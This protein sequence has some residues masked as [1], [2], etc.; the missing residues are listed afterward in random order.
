MSS[1]ARRAAIQDV[2]RRI[3]LTNTEP[4]VALTEIFA[5]NVF[6]ERVQRQR[7]PKRVYGLLRETTRSGR[8]L[9]PTI[10]DAVASAMRDWAVE[11]GATHYS[12]WFQPMTGLT[13]EK[14]DSFISLTEDER[15]INEFSG[16]DLIR[17]EPD[18]SSF[19]SGGLRSTFEARGYTAWDPTSPAFIRE[20][21][22][23]KTLC[24]PTV[25]CS[26]TGEALDK[27]TPLLRSEEAIN[28]ASVRL[29][30]LIGNDR[31]TQVSTTI[32]CEQEYFLVDRQ[33]AHLRPDLLA[34]G[35][36]LFGARPPKGQEMSD[37]YFGAISQRALAFMQDLEIDLWR[38]GIPVK[39]RHNEVA[40]MQFELAPIF[41]HAPVSSD[42]NMMIMEMLKVVA[43]RHGLRCL[44]HEKPFTGVNGSGKHTNWSL[45]D[46]QGNNLLEPGQGAEDNLQFVLFLTAIIRAV[47][48]HADLMRVS[49]AHA[50]NDHRL[51]ANEAPPAIIS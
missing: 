17:G 22:H 50:S 15:I 21:P 38:L 24:I 34:C 29:L 32:G 3:P 7:L 19:P 47:D 26:W 27:K 40:P 8:G 51:G 13:A 10:A 46:D 20:G 18:A 25:F 12:H 28:R 23:G 6:N 37:N 33:M 30:Q 16:S 35:R 31:V 42:Q 5:V 41:R 36:T 9:D 4:Q 43:E 39:T 49:I 48:L 14:H 2:S 45:T 44:L 11:R 1:D